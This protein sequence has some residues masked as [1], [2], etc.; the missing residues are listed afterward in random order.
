VSDPGPDITL[1]SDGG[2]DPAAG[3]SASPPVDGPPADLRGVL[4]ALLVASDTPLEPDDVGAALTVAAEEIRAVLAGLAEEYQ[5]QGRGFRLRET[6]TGWRLF[7]APEHHDTVR[8][9][10]VDASPVRLTQAALETLA[11]VAY[12]QPVSR[13]RVAAIRGVNVDAVIRTLVTRGLITEVDQDEST[14]ALL[15]GTTAQFLEKVGLRDLTEL[16]PL[17]DY[18]PED[19][20]F[21]SIVEQVSTSE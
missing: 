1:D 8:R 9:L 11:V 18:L 20:A 7:C 5:A 10:V 15:Y 17:V 12:Q 2:E 16:P 21:R 19:E 6:A 3:A 13:G 14:G 4:E